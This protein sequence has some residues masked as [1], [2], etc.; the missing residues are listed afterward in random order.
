MVFME[1]EFLGVFH[2]A[3]KL[4]AVDLGE[5]ALVEATEGGGGAVER[6]LSQVELKLSKLA[7]LIHWSSGASKKIVSASEA[8]YFE[9]RVLDKIADVRSGLL[10]VRIADGDQ[11]EEEEEVGGGSWSLEGKFQ[12]FIFFMLLILY[13]LCLYL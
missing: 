9:E 4:E 3:G 13:I 5:E 6:V 2:L 7:N 8:A 11:E 10:R 12:E 1:V